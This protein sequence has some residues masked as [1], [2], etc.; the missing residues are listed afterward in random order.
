VAGDGD[1]T[2]ALSCSASAQL[3]DRPI[4]GAVFFYWYEWDESEE[5]ENWIEG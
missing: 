5:W 3:L 1:L 4:V 2:A